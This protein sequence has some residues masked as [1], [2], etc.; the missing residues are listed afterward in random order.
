MTKTTNQMKTKT[1]NTA[2][3]LKFRNSNISEFQIK[4]INGINGMADIS[5]KHVMVYAKSE[6]MILTAPFIVQYN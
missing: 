5:N 4:S 6:W 1:F 3:D 2:K